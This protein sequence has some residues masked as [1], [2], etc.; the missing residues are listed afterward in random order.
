MSIFLDRGARSGPIFGSKSGHGNL[1]VPT[2]PTLCRAHLRRTLG[3][4]API[5]GRRFVTTFVSVPR[6]CYCAA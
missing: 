1:P 4:N 6:G 2:Y 5:A 3:N